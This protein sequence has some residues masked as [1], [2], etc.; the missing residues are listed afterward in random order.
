MYIF[1]NCVIILAICVSIILTIYNSEQYGNGDTKLF[2]YAMIT[3]CCLIGMFFLISL[4]LDMSYKNGQVDA[5]NGKQKY[6]LVD[7]KVA[8]LIEVKR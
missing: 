7:T 3:V 2:V 6:K 5:L 8:E 1:V 4:S